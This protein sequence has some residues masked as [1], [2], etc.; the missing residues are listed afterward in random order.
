[1]GEYM[2]KH[3]VARLIGAPPGYVGHEE[4]G[5][6]TEAVSGEQRHGRGWRAYTATYIAAQIQV[7]LTVG[8]DGLGL[9]G[10]VQRACRAA[11]IVALCPAYACIRAAAGCS[12]CILD[13]CNQLTQCACSRF[14]TSAL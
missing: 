5:Q 12:T 1:M 10:G 8:S 14:S 6:L 4:G 2:E 3:S 13:I 11:H 7:M 9:V